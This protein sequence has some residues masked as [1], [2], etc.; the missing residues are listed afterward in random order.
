LPWAVGKPSPISQPCDRHFRSVRA[1][2]RLGH[3]RYRDLS[4]AKIFELGPTI[5]RLARAAEIAPP[6][7]AAS[8]RASNLTAVDIAVELSVLRSTLQRG[9]N[10]GLGSAN[11]VRVPLIYI[12]RSTWAARWAAKPLQGLK[13]LC[14]VDHPT[15][16]VGLVREVSSGQDSY[17]FGSGMTHWTASVVAILLAGFPGVASAQVNC[18]A[19]AH[20]PA[21]TDC[22]LGLSE[23]YRGQSDLAAARARVQ[24]DAAWYRAITGT[25]PP[26][27]RPPRRR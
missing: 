6:N 27:H 9:E 2:I 26:K 13:P 1:S 18:E 20:G 24:S 11:Q 12:N 21:R 5:F 16:R 10:F 19:I 17:A 23:F 7:S 25:D 14:P 22:Y 4:G 8:R 15:L 3:V